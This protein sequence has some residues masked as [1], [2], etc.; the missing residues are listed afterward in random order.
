MPWTPVTA[1]DEERSQSRARLAICL[2]SLLGFY[3][4]VK[5]HHLVDGHTTIVGFATI[6]GYLTFA[7]AWHAIIARF[8]NRC[9]WRR[10]VGMFADLGIMVY[11]MHLGDEY[12]TSY[13]PIFLWVIIGNGIRFGPRY[14]KM[15][16][17]MGTTGFTVLLARDSYWA[18]N[19]ALGVGLLIGVIVLPV[20]FLTVLK[21]LQAVSR[22]EVELAKSRLA[23]KAKDEFLATMSHEL[24][25]PMNGVLGMA[26]LLKDSVLDRQQREQVDV[27]TRSVDSLL[28]II[29]DILDY[30][31]ISANRLTL[32]AIP[33][34]LERVLADVYRLLATTAEAQGISL[35]FEYPD[36]ELRG[37]LGD[38]TRVRQIALNLV[39]NAIKFTPAGGVRLRCRVVPDRSRGNVIMEVADTG[40]GIPANRH[41]AI[42]D[43]FEQVDNSVT[44]QHGGSGLGLAISQQ[45]AQ[46]MGGEITVRSEVGAGS[47]FTVSLS[48]PPAEMPMAKSEP[49][50]RD[51]PRFKLRALVVEDNPFNQM[52]T[53]Q[54]LLKLGIASKVAENGAVALEMIDAADYDIV[55]MDIRMPVMDG[56]E[57]SRRIRARGDARAGIPII[58]ITAEATSQAQE[59]CLAA[60]MTDYLA[61][62][63]RMDR[64]AAAIAARFEPVAEA[65]PREA[66]DSGQPVNV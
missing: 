29:N 17:A 66:H 46:M 57:A 50:T 42:F 63:L 36:V 35:H 26:E 24:R 52:V 44:R 37:F 59:Q 2:V 18:Q 30:S 21:R 56:Y 27:I 40:I 19:Q 45:L 49:A 38:P 5:S 9:L 32:E 11:W 3:I 58:A 1:I 43:V 55:F 39:G 15:G 20:F 65:T 25:T 4:I 13:Y 61:K 41:E 51:L 7:L 14:L 60:G 62:P 48:L 22:L 47:T 31:K 28:N 8:P 64:M 16:I 33:F 23:D 12:V 54:T 6:L 10:Y 34:N 53:K